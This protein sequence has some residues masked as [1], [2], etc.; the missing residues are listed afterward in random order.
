[1]QPNITIMKKLIFSGLIIFLLTSIRSTSRAQLTYNM[2]KFSPEIADVHNIPS[3]PNVAK[4]SAGIPLGAIRNFVKTYEN[5]TA[6]KWSRLKNGRSVVHFFSDS[7]ETKIFYNRKGNA[8]GMIR[9]YTEDKLPYEVRHLVKSTYYD[10]S[11]FLVVEVTVNK[12]TV[13]QVKIE[14]TT[15]SKTISVIDMEMEVTEV[16]E[17]S[18]SPHH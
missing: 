17:K 10:F 12:K 5:A 7:I 15:C 3:A 6:V 1:M 4:A 8:A 2:K 13:Y 18:F 9:Y 16:L 14:D 11:I